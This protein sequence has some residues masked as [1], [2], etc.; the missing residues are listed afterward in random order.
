MEA[1]ARD[2]IDVWNNGAEELANALLESM[3]NDPKRGGQYK[4]EDMMQIVRGGN[5]IIGELLEHGTTEGRDAYINT[6]IPG[7]HAQGETLPMMI[8]QTVFIQMQMF[9]MA[10]VRVKPEHRADASKFFIRWCMDFQRDI[11]TVVLE[12]MGKG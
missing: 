9:Q 4:L 8:S 7:I 3:T 12:A 6:V 10:I 2:L 11:A 1:W 5:A